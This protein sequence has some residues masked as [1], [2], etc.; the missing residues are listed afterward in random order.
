MGRRE[1]C[2]VSFQIL[3][4]L[5]IQNVTDGKQASVRVPASR[6]FCRYAW[7]WL[8]LPLKFCFDRKSALRI[9]VMEKWDGERCD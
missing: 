2:L 1:A 6:A 3:E 5:S 7:A 4:R 9:C 8:K